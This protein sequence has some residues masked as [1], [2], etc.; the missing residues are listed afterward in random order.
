MQGTIQAARGT[1]T[2]L[3][4]AAVVAALVIP[5]ALGGTVSA[6]GTVGTT[7]GSPDPRDAGIIFTY[8]PGLVASTLGSPDPRNTAPAFSMAHLR[9]PA[10]VSP[11]ATGTVASKL[12]SPDP[13][14]TA[15]SSR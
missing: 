2:A 6:P 14:D 10:G 12:G 1:L 4:S 8:A 5:T 15:R 9:E 13:R 3:A 11:F 7:L